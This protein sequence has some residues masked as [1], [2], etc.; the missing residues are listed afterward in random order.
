MPKRLKM[1]FLNNLMVRGQDNEGGGDGDDAQRADAPAQQLSQEELRRRRVERLAGSASAAPAATAAP[2]TPA[3][4]AS[5]ARQAKVQVQAQTA[6]SSPEAAP[7]K[8][9]PTTTATTTTTASASAAGAPDEARQR[10]AV[11][12]ALCT[13]LRVTLSAQPSPALVAAGD[14]P[15]YLAQV[16]QDVRSTAVSRENLD[17][18][19]YARLAADPNDLVP[20][21]GES[22]ARYLFACYER[23]QSAKRRY[24]G[25]GAALQELEALLVSYAATSLTEPGMFPMSAF[26]KYGGRPADASPVLELLDLVRE[27][28]TKPAFAWMLEALADAAA[29][30]ETAAQIAEPV[31]RQLAAEAKEVG[32]LAEERLPESALRALTVH[33]PF[34]V[35]LARAM[36]LELGKNLA[37]G[38][39]L[40]APGFFG[41]VSHARRVELETVLGPMLTSA[42]TWRRSLEQ[43]RPFSETSTELVNREHFRDTVDAVHMRQRARRADLGETLVNVCRASAD[44]RNAVLEWIAYALA[45]DAEQVKDRPNR[46]KAS[47][48]G[49]ANS[50]SAV[51][52]HACAPFLTADGTAVGAKHSSHAAM[53]VREAGAVLASSRA[54]PADETRL[55]GPVSAGP[56]SGGPSGPSGAGTGTNSEFKFVP[57]VFVLALRALHQGP[58]A[59]L[60]HVRTLQRQLSFMS[61]QLGAAEAPQNSDYR[62][63]VCEVMCYE[64][65]AVE[66]ESI[67][68]ALMLYALATRWIMSLQLGLDGD[69]DWRASARSVVPLVADASEVAP[70]VRALPEHVVSDMTDMVLTTAQIGALH[71]LDAAPKAALRDLLDFFVVAMGSPKFVYSPHVRA[72]MGDAVFF[73]FLPQWALHPDDDDGL[74]RASRR[75]VRPREQAIEESLVSQRHLVPVLMQLYADVEATGFYESVEHRHKIALVIR[76][77]WELPGHRDSFRAFA[78][79]ASDDDTEARTPFVKF[80]MGLFKQTN[81]N[82]TDSLA[83][84]KEIRATLAERADAARWAALSAQDREQREQMLDDNTAAVR[85]ALQLA[86]EVTEMIKYLSTDRE[87]ARALTVPFL[88]A[89]LVNMLG[90][91]LT[92][93]A[94]KARHAELQLDDPRSYNFHPEQMLTRVLLTLGNVAANVT[95]PDAFVAALSACAYY[96]YDVFQ[97]AADTVRAY[98][99]TDSAQAQRFNELNRRCREAR[100]RATVRERER[101]EP[102]EEFLDAI[103]QEVMVDPVQLPSS[104]SVVDRATISTHLLGQQNDPFDRSP[105]SVDQVVSLPDLKRRIEA[106]MESGEP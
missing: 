7:A 76:H 40:P 66:R 96:D 43:F 105:L 41:R 51:V 67:S 5:P 60:R 39:L 55:V 85:G 45:L 46:A 87:F 4:T 44:A 15:V 73:A 102:P 50:L 72:R 18:V 32:P 33:K 53:I 38:V 69:A 84:L 36:R 58:I 26:A 35:E 88:R 80:A 37:E 31:F 52:L 2:S 75:T 9:S 19:V 17:A 83:K 34:Q 27:S 29:A 70:A 28:A 16:A 8:P 14:K 48:P 56:G 6:S 71:V 106:W 47:S 61:R 78:A 93:L 20:R 23:L 100:E 74:G 24:P 10:A 82:V 30:Q 99:V 63:F 42:G 91:I 97:R 89:P 81:T 90:S 95:D 22:P 12:D 49:F 68:R 103:T 101:G 77:L 59:T 1:N 25:A 21:P 94:S 54:F 98:G 65:D 86:N 64:C 104:K 3:A 57:R 79:T 62:A 13:V 92:P 11:N